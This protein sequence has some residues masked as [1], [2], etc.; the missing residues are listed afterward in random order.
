MSDPN[1]P[2]P[3]GTD[4]PVPADAPRID[5]A[6]PEPEPESDALVPMTALEQRRLD[7]ARARTEAARRAAAP[8]PWQPPASTAVLP[9]GAITTPDGRIVMPMPQQQLTSYG[10]GALP[11]PAAGYP[12][13]A[14]PV[15]ATSGAYGYGAVG[16]GSY[17]TPA[18]PMPAYPTPAAAPAAYAQP[19]AY[20][21][22]AQ[23]PK[24]PLTRPQRRAALLGSLLGQTLFAI[25]GH[26]LVTFF[27]ATGVIALFQYGM[28]NDTQDMLGSFTQFVSYW[29][30]PDRYWMLCIFALLLFAI[31]VLL[32][33]ASSA[34][35]QRQTGLARVHA[36]IA[37]G[38]ATT[39][40]ATSVIG[41]VLWPGTV[42]FGGFGLLFSGFGSTTGE[43][44]MMLFVPVTIA[45]LVCGVV[46]ML[47]QWMYLLVLRPR[48]TAADLE[49]ERAAREAED[50]Q[51]AVAADV[52]QLTHVE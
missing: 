26:F 31:I 20:A 48:P 45:A 17:P 40:L 6:R 7:R 51:R 50:E 1:V 9:G 38:W 25:A 27:I 34:I 28:P 49:A 4:T 43:L 16:Y 42:L 2:P 24:R 22:I 13:P 39:A 12:A 8:A 52:A 21:P 47:F 23:I 29:T 19:L 10:T 11:S 41:L 32:G 44:W 5:V 36:A 33:W 15:Q 46:G 14:Y 18:Y 37:L 35:W 3:P 30:H